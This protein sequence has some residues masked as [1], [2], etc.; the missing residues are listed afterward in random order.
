V[1]ATGLLISSIVNAASFVQS[2]AAPNTVMVAFGD[3]PGCSTGSSLL[4]EG[5]QAAI[6]FISSTEIYFVT[7]P[8]APSSQ[9]S[10]VQIRCAGAVS[11]TFPIAAAAS[12]PAVFTRSGTG[13]GQAATVND[14]GSLGQPSRANTATTVYVTGFGLVRPPGSDGLARLAQSVTAS[15]G[16][17]PAVVAYAGAV[18]GFTSGLQQ[19]SVLIPGDVPHGTSVPLQFT[20]EGVPT[21]AGVTLAIE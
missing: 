3:F 20:V 12:A 8:E 13:V 16:G 5:V 10:N 11:Q 14:D 18:A 9:S 19:I 2:P 17:K 15:I 6:L 7:P 21:Q 1:A 4:V